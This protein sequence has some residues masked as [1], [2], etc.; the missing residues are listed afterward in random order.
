MEFIL[1]F[2]ISAECGDLHFL[3]KDTHK[4]NGVSNKTEVFR[5]STNRDILVTGALNELL[6]FN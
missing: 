4:Q 3:L 2:Y 5:K 1:L 6:F